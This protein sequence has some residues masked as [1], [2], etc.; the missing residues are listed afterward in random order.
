MR[1]TTRRFILPLL[2]LAASAAGALTGC[3]PPTVRLPSGTGAAQ[4][5]RNNCYS[6]LHQLLD[7]QKDV[8]MLRFIKQ[9]HSDLKELTKKIAAVSGA[10][11]QLLEEFARHDHS[12]NLNDIRL[13][14][15]EVATRK[16]IA[17]GKKEELL[18]HTGDDFELSLLLSQDEALTYAWRLA[19]VGGENDAQPDRAREMAGVG[20]DMKKLH[21]E[22]VAMLLLK[23]PMHVK[24]QIVAGK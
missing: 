9:E 3:Q 17:S 12:I 16:A 15:G 4:M 18:G 8:S 23:A 1:A 22:V 7:E 10:G 24:K 2:A 6:L 20:E 19:T 14:P 13:P 21:Q 5:T 11:S